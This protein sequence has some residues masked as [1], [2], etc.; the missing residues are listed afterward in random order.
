MLCTYT[1]DTCYAGRKGTGQEYIFY[2][3]IISL[4][5][6]HIY[7]DVKTQQRPAPTARLYSLSIFK[8][9]R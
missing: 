3:W 4:G 2:Y 5:T 9:Y 6:F 8:T 1:S 7:Y